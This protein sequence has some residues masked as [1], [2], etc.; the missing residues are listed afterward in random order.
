M[1]RQNILRTLLFVVFFSIGATAMYASII[2]NELIGLYHKRQLL[3]AKQEDTSRMESLNADYDAVLE[4]VKK[5]PNL[6]KRIAPATLGT[7]P[8]NK[9]AVYPKATPEQLDAARKVL[10]EDSDRHTEDSMIPV[11]LARCSEPLQR[12]ILFLSGGFLILVSFVCFAP[13]KQSNQ[14]D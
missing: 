6:I 9:D 8:E 13:A 2:C 7:E 3:K 10:T 5:D 1:Q 11:W 12:V 4:Q 14:G